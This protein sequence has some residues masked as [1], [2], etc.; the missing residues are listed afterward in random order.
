MNQERRKDA[1][2]VIDYLNVDGRMGSSQW[3]LQEF[4]NRVKATDP[5]LTVINTSV[6][7]IPVDC[8]IAVVQ[9]VLADR[10]CRKSAP[11]A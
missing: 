4:R 2:E 8:D 6:D 1:D 10:A 9:A 7:N 5:D 11:Q 3:E